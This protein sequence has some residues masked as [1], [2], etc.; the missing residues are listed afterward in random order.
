VNR[1][2][3]NNP[4]TPLLKAARLALVLALVSTLAA[5]ATKPPASDPVALAAYEEANDPL[6]PLNRAMFKVDAGLDQ[7]I[8][9]PVIKTYRFIVPEGGRKSVDNFVNNLHT[10]V[11]FVN[12]ILQ[13][14]ISRAGVTLGR[15][16]VNTTVGFLG[17]FDVGEKIGLPFHS[18]DFGQTLGAWGLGD[19]P[20]LY[21]PLLGPSTV[22]D[23]TGFLIDSFAVDPLAWY[24]RGDGSMAWVQWA[25]FGLVY[26][27]TKD[28]T[29]DI[30]DELKKSS[31]DYYA[32]LRSSYRQI[33]ASE[34]RNGAPPPMEDFDE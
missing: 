14:E 5:C 10:P 4:G 8:V 19:G 15:F 6:E 3:K 26:I 1:S 28:M 9:R 33:R 17:F 16:V 24:N 27:D 31:L 22:R 18:E 11:T 23:G 32:A 29:M 7:V 13:G 25:N 20:Y 21:I 34:V 12:D 2:A 30:L